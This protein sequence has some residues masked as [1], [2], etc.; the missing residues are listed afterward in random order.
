MVKGDYIRI[1]F[2]QFP[3]ITYLSNETFICNFLINIFLYRTRNL[4]LLASRILNGEAAEPGEFPWMV[5]LIHK[6]PHFLERI[7]ISIENLILCFQGC[8]WLLE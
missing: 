1:K 2:K 3:L 4:N 6:Q 7:L 5:E 8:P